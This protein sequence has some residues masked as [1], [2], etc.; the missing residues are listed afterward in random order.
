M[1][2]RMGVRRSRPAHT[3]VRGDRPGT[4][5]GLRW[6]RSNATGRAGR[7]SD[8]HDACE[9]KSNRLHTDRPRPLIATELARFC[10]RTSD[11]WGCLIL[12]TD[13]SSGRFQLC[14]RI[15]AP[16]SGVLERRL[17]GKPG[18]ACFPNWAGAAC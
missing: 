14:V 1:L 5:A 10:V 12:A 9:R 3:P 15:K 6:L 4:A 16:R 13:A 8:G 2:A 7:E 11:R 18:V 17:L